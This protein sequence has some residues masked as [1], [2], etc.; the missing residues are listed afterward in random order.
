MSRNALLL[1]CLVVLAAV[2][3]SAFGNGQVTGSGIGGDEEFRWPPPA[4]LIVNL[5]SGNE[6]DANS[7]GV[8]PFPTGTSRTAYQ[9]PPG[10]WLVVTQP[11]Y[12]TRA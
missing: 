4:K 7:N 9:V 12:P 10:H 3:G 2:V 1:V 5:D 11:G 8:I 6:P